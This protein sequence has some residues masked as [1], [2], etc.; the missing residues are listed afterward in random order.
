MKLLPKAI[1]SITKEKAESFDLSTF[2]S[3][4]FDVFDK[5]S[6]GTY[7][8]QFDEILANYILGYCAYLAEDFFSAVSIFN[9]VP[10]DCDLYPYVKYNL[11]ECFFKLNDI[12]SFGKLLQ[13]VKREEKPYF[14]AQL[15]IIKYLHQLNK[16]QEFA[17]RL[18]NLKHESSI[19]NDILAEIIRFLIDI[20][21][22]SNVNSFLNKYKDLSLEKML[23]HQ[24]F[25]SS[26][27]SSK[28][29]D[30]QEF[31]GKEISHVCLRD[32]YE[33]CRVLKMAQD[34]F[35][36][37]LQ[38][39]ILKSKTPDEK[40]FWNSMKAY[41]EQNPEGCLE[42]LQKISEKFYS[43]ESVYCLVAFCY[44]QQDRKQEA[45]ELLKQIPS[46]IPDYEII[47]YQ[48][49]ELYILLN[50]LEEVT[51]LVSKFPQNSEFYNLVNYQMAKMQVE[52]KLFA[53][54]KN[55]LALV[56]P[57]SSVF[58]RAQILLEDQL[59]EDYETDAE[60]EAEGLPAE[61]NLLKIYKN[62][63]DELEDVKRFFK[64]Q[65]N[66]FDKDYKRKLSKKHSIF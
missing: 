21:D 47:Q 11:A 39:K 22:Y 65:L 56:E 66:R 2:V 14:N 30:Y 15:R 31:F 53:I 12:P 48:L 24:K 55:R 38:V 8:D 29:N 1:E 18:E 62:E 6:F 28:P 50:N 19:S 42:N 52:K 60:I 54:A 35:S 10:K 59:Y 34:L 9:K 63:N 45:V 46:T 26:F 27:Y 57:N 61:V 3:M 13:L 36:K 37:L 64:F 5:F 44:A 16:M 20:D 17:Q 23:L 58:V 4:I 51:K 32:V 40:D 43:I 7:R 49:F 41:L 33:I 25:Q